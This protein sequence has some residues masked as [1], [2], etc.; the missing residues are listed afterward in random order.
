MTG[1]A[2]AIAGISPLPVLT[3]ELVVAAAPLEKTGSAAAMSE[4]S[5]ELG[6]GLGVALNGSL[7]AAVFAARTA[8]NLRR[9]TIWRAP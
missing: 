3:T 8:S 2:I 5:G 4:T 9:A 1:S 6:V 7:V